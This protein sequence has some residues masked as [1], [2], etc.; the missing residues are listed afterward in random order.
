MNNESA[1]EKNITHDATYYVT[2]AFFALITSA[3]PAVLGQP[4]FLP[5]IQTL[6]LT[7]FVSVAL[8]NRNLR[9]AGQVMALW[10]PIQFIVIVVLTRTFLGQ[11]E[12]AFT[13]GF[14]YRAAITAWFFGGAPHPAGL[15]AHPLGFVTEFA[16][17]AIG[18]LL[19]AGLVGVWFLVRLINLAAYGTGI[20]LATL[21]NLGLVLLVIPYWTLLRAAGHAA[22]IVLCAMPLLTYRWSPGYYWREHRQWL[23][24]ALTLIILGIVAE[25]IIPGLATQTP[26]N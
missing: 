12:H 14:A 7:T 10:V 19:T 6:A 22:L 2:A 25:L 8:H 16:M 17:M 5:I 4:R 24:V 18:S 23:V 21:P 13:E 3:L 20:L 1:T 9:G 26:V 15:A 11:V